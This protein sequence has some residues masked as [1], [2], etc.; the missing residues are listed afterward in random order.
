M[1]FCCGLEKNG[2]AKYVYA[3]FPVNA[4]KCCVRVPKDFQTTVWDIHTEVEKTELTT[5][6]D[7]WLIETFLNL[8][9]TVGSCQ[10][11]IETCKEL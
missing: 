1:S 10:E 3:L 7:T 4:V 11:C 5:P 2:G 8:N 9:H 6:V